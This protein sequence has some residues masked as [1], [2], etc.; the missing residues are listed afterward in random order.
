MNVKLT[1]TQI[2]REHDASRKI[3]KVLRS[4][5]ISNYGFEEQSS[6]KVRGFLVLCFFFFFFFIPETLE[7]VTL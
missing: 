3:S 7:K 6:T 4:N 5:L 2:Q 1:S